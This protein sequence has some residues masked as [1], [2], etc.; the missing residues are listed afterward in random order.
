MGRKEYPL[1]PDGS[2][3]KNPPP[4]EGK[5]GDRCLIPG[6][7]R[8][9]EEGNGNPLQ[10]S[11]LENPIDRKAWRVTAHGVIKSWT[12]LSDL[13]VKES[14]V[15][16]VLSDSAGPHGLYS[17]PGSSIW[18]L[19]GKSTAVGCH[20]LLQGIFPTQ[21]AHTLLSVMHRTSTSHPYNHLVR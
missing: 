13:K 20:F 9:P 4:N 17:L 10:Y 15:A 3:V 7:G 5:T 19:P 18:N 8:S 6:W 14:E 21:G 1:V 12:G 16:Q 11:C 2:V